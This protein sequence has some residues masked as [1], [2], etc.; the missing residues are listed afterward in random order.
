MKKL[1]F[2]DNLI[3]KLIFIKY[4]LNSMKCLYYFR[5]NYFKNILYCVNKINFWDYNFSIIDMDFLDIMKIIKN[6]N[7]IRK[8]FS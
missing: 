8:K 5:W 3:K 6:L 4:R 2:F 1:K 7:F